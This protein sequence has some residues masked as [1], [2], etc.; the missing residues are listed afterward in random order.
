MLFFLRGKSASGLVTNGFLPI[1][2]MWDI[3]LKKGDDDDCNQHKGFQ[4]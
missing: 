2:V 1:F 4:G 3:M